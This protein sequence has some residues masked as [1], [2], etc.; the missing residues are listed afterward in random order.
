MVL[1]IARPSTV[2][3]K[4][5]PRS[6][7]LKWSA[8]LKCGNTEVWSHELGGLDLPGELKLRHPISIL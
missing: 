7:Q 5:L 8:H 3:L 2:P 6:G 1:R 4:T